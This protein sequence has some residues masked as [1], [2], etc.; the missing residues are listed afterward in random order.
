MYAC[1]YHNKTKSD[2]K[3]ENAIVSTSIKNPNS[4]GV[5]QTFTKLQKYKKNRVKKKISTFYSQVFVCVCE[6]GEQMKVPFRLL[7]V[8]KR[9]LFTMHKS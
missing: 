4:S 3:I 1:L 2:S 5:M 8:D 7:N 6:C 9:K